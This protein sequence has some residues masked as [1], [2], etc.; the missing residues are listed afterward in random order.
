[1]IKAKKDR[2]MAKTMKLAALL[3]AVLALL[4]AVIS[5]IS[6]APEYYK[7]GLLL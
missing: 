3:S 2:S 6:A 4:S 5:E 1:M 7:T